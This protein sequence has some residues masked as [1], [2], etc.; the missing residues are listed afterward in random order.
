MRGIWL[1]LCLLV[2]LVTPT[3][4][5]VFGVP[6]SFLSRQVAHSVVS[7]SVGSVQSA[8]C[9]ISPGSG[10]SLNCTN[11]TIAAGTNLALICTLATGVPAPTAP[12]MTWN[13]VSMTLIGYYNPANTVS[14]AFFGLVAPATGN[15]T[16]AASWT[17]ST[18]N[19]TIFCITFQNVNQSG[20]A[21]SFANFTGANGTSAAPSVTVASQTGDFVIGALSAT[22]VNIIGSVGQ[23]TWFVD[24]FPNNISTAGNYTTGSASVSLTAVISG[25]T[26]IFSYAGLDVVHQ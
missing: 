20:G 22:G 16:A 8:A 25:G 21:T 2:A 1:V 18:S 14:V 5:D 10:T 3:L 24:N 9:D 4:A 19:A 6:P 23:T 12:T 15:H 7:V 26:D 11:M 17:T 13:G